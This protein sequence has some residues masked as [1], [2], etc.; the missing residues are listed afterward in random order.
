MAMDL[1]RHNYFNNMASDLLGHQ[2]ASHNVCRM[3][4]E[5]GRDRGPGRTPLSLTL[6]NTRVN[7]L[8]QEL[9]DHEFKDLDVRI[10]VHPSIVGLAVCSARPREQWVVDPMAFDP[11]QSS[12][13]QTYFNP[14]VLDRD[15]WSSAERFRQEYQGDFVPDEVAIFDLPNTPFFRRMT[16]ESTTESQRREIAR[17]LSA[18][19]P[20]IFGHKR[21]RE[22]K[23]D[24]S[25]SA[26][27]M[28]DNVEFIELASELRGLCR[29]LGCRDIISPDFN[30]DAL[31]GLE[32]PPDSIKPD[33]IC[34]Y[35]A[36]SLVRGLFLNKFEKQFIDKNAALLGVFDKDAVLA[37]ASGIIRAR[38]YY[39]F[40]RRHYIKYGKS[41]RY[42]LCLVSGN[43]HLHTDNDFEYSAEY[44]LPHSVSSFWDNADYWLDAT[45][46]YLRNV[47]KDVEVFYDDKD[48]VFYGSEDGAKK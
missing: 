16:I 40:I 29:D 17:G 15:H 26:Q 33:E 8:I 34:E 44:S 36:C 12:R 20:L 32:H 47:I 7:R 14:S 5:V 21:E 23:P 25:L 27:E 43:L 1:I 41:Y 48:E 6:A 18:P 30:F 42:K 2:S 4:Q 38:P 10:E 22:A 37:I 9:V 13:R 31:L 24:P 39:I 11:F 46:R 45:T 35:K 28:Y 19:Q 3:R